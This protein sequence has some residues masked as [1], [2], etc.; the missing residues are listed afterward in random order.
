MLSLSRGGRRLLSQGGWLHIVAL[1][2]PQ[3]LHTEHSISCLASNS[4]AMAAL[5][6]KCDHG[7]LSGPT[8]TLCHTY[9][10][11]SVPHLCVLYL[12]DTITS[13][14]QPLSTSGSTYNLFC[15]GGRRRHIRATTIAFTTPGAAGKGEPRSTRRGVAWRW[16]LEPSRSR[17]PLANA[18]RQ[19]GAWR[20]AEEGHLPA[21]AEERTTASSRLWRGGVG[22][23]NDCR[24]AGSSSRAAWRQ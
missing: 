8:I 14:W 23:K 10:I 20:K 16:L 6:I 15:C 11:P 21:S 7:K 5:Y 9:H 18:G 3:P 22:K 2:L 4:H 24:S 13:A 17:L 12:L 1:W 19:K